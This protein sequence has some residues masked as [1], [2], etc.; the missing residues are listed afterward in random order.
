MLIADWC[1]L[2][3]IDYDADW[4][5]VMLN[6][7]DRCS[8]PVNQIF[9]ERTSGL[10]SFFFKKFPLS[11]VNIWWNPSYLRHNMWAAPSMAWICQSWPDSEQQSAIRVCRTTNWCILVPG[12]KLVHIPLAETPIS[13]VLDKMRQRRPWTNINLHKSHSPLSVDFVAQKKMRIRSFYQI[14]CDFQQFFSLH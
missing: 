5:W 3:L 9:S 8:N 1:L 7:A 4:F 13:N 6:D 10:R 12:N 2:M 14:F 11:I